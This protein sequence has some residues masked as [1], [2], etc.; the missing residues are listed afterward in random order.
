MLL[1]HKHSEPLEEQS[2]TFKPNSLQPI[3][4]LHAVARLPFILTCLFLFPS[5]LPFLTSEKILH[6]K[7]RSKSCLSCCQG[8]SPGV[9]EPRAHHLGHLYCSYSQSLAPGAAKSKSGSLCK[10]SALGPVSSVARIL[11]HLPQESEI[12]PRA[13]PS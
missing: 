9:K 12:R 8:D 13:Q 4:T 7:Q 11:L 6:E 1:H 3:V 2:V 5:I 10:P